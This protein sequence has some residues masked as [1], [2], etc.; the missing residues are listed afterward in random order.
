MEADFDTLPILDGNL[1]TSP[2]YLTRDNDFPNQDPISNKK[3]SKAKI[4]GVK[5]EKQKKEKKEKV[6][7]CRR[8]YKSWDEKKLIA[9]FANFQKRYLQSKSRFVKSEHRF[10]NFMYEFEKRGM[11]L[12]NLIDEEGNFLCGGQETTLNKQTL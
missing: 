4:T 9:H 1:C 5:K 10:Q 6:A 12:H 7:R 2:P 8:P 11:T 3:K